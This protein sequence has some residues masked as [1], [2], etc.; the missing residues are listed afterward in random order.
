M[1]FG[2]MGRE[3]SRGEDAESDRRLQAVLQDIVGERI[4]DVMGAIPTSS[5]KLV[6]FFAVLY[7]PNNP[8]S[9]SCPSRLRSSGFV[10]PLSRPST[11]SSTF[12][13]TCSC[14]FPVKPL[15]STP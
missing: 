13:F 4:D 7:R 1:P 12:F 8:L 3:G 10:V 15:I 2:Y 11:A 9:N 5:S 6:S 14:T